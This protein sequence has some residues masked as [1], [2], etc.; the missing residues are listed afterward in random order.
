M[1]FDDVFKYRYLLGLYQFNT[2]I[3]WHILLDSISVINNS[4]D[5]SS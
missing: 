3:L 2:C 4:S 5:S 1:I